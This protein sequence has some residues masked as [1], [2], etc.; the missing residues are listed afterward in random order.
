MTEAFFV[1]EGD[2]LFRST[3]HTIGPWS[4][5]SQHAGPPAALLGRAI[6][7]ASGRSEMQTARITF[8]ILRPVPIETL[9]GEAEVTRGGKSVEL[10]EASLSTEAGP[11]MRARGWRIRRADL[12]VK[13]PEPDPSP[14]PP[15]ERGGEQRSFSRHGYMAAMET[16]FVKGAFFEPGPATAWFR[17]RYPLIENEEVSPLTR[18][19][20]ASDSGNGISASIDFREWV[21]INPDLT[22]YLHRLPEGEWV[23]LDAQ[24][25]IQPAGIGLATSVISDRTGKIGRG[26]QSLFVA[27]R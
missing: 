9:R 7:A 8:E 18:V 4:D 5:E 21:F 6:E 23:C 3:E 25:V 27:P 20:I 10:L 16:C 15:P 14:P 22:V 26:L 11:V 17:M 24:T 19:L 2:G 12:D 1:P 13:V